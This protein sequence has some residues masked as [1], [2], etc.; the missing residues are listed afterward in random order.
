MFYSIKNTEVVRKKIL[1]FVKLKFNVGKAVTRNWIKITYNNYYQLPWVHL[2]RVLLV[3]NI[4]N[5]F[6]IGNFYFATALVLIPKR[7]TTR[8]VSLLLFNYINCLISNKFLNLRTSLFS[9]F[10]Y[11]TFLLSHYEIQI[12]LSLY[13]SKDK[14]VKLLI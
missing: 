1:S 14:N 13:Q 7:H 10:R 6:Q 8:R 2:G 9:A 12:F 3:F 11:I 5:C 4:P